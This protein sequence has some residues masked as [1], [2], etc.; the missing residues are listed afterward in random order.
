MR[1]GL[2]TAHD[3]ARG[4]R[5]IVRRGISRDAAGAAR[6]RAAPAAS[7]GRAAMGV[8]RAPP[9]GPPL[10]GGAGATLGRVPRAPGRRRPIREDGVNLR[11]VEPHMSSQHVTDRLTKVGGHRE[12][13]LLI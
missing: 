4:A 8:R 1:S 5:S 3:G 10:Q 6:V 9:G 12:V 11:G 13:A 7:P 2:A